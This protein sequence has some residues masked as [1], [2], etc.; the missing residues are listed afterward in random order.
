MPSYT[1]LTQEERYQIYVL[2]QAGHKQ[3][4]IA[5]L[6]NQDPVAA[7]HRDEP[8]YCLAGGELGLGEKVGGGQDDC[9]PASLGVTGVDDF[10]RPA[11]YRVVEG[12]PPRKL[13]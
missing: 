7:Q 9:G 10:P 11:D 4:E 1:Q 8:R 5:V 13:Q 3:C 6:L 12:A 2:R